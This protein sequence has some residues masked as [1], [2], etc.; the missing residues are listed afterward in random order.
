M[1]CGQKKKKKKLTVGMFNIQ[2]DTAPSVGPLIR[3]SHV[4]YVGW[5]IW[6]QRSVRKGDQKYQDHHLQYEFTFINV[7]D[8][9]HPN[10]IVW[11]EIWANDWTFK[12]ILG[13]LIFIYSYFLPIVV[14]QLTSWAAAPQASLSFTIS[15]GLL[16]LMST[17]SV[18][19]PN[20]LIFYCS[21]SPL[22]LSLSQHQGLF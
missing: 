3:W 10:C 12:V 9:S 18:M 6:V 19:L 8:E 4:S 13:S 21:L 14:V 15:Q 7:D 5:G 17:E 16:K 11:L 22:A 2:I 1:L 20:H